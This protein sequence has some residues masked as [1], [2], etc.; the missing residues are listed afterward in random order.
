[1]NKLFHFGAL[2]VSVS[3]IVPPIPADS[4]LCPFLI[5]EGKADLQII[6]FQDETFPIPDDA[7][8]IYFSGIYRVRQKG[9]R[10][11]HTAG[12]DRLDLR[13]FAYR[14]FRPKQSPAPNLA[15]KFQND[16]GQPV[17]QRDDGKPDACP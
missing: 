15:A 1:M 11:L 5:D 4:L 14:F 9:G 10:V 17:V 12:R 3:G 6:V 16:N 13:C 8:E 2:T 7:K